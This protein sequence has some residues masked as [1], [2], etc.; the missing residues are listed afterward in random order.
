MNRDRQY[1]GCYVFYAA[2]FANGIASQSVLMNIIF[3]L[4]KFYVILSFLGA[5]RS[6][7]AC[8]KLKLIFL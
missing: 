5:K 4:A 2:G 3:V 7:I 6:N 1:N 8:L